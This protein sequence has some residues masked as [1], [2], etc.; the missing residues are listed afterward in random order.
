MDFDPRLY[1][2]VV[3][4]MSLPNLASLFRDQPFLL[5]ILPFYRRVNSVLFA[6]QLEPDVV[7][8][9]VNYLWVLMVSSNL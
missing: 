5:L 3:N 8:L 9:H 2:L 6:H 1:N 4:R 7:I